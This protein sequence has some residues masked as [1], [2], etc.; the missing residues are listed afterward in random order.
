MAVVPLET[1]SNDPRLEVGD[2]GIDFL[3]SVL[4]DKCSVY[5]DIFKWRI[6]PMMSGDARMKK[7]C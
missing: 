1:H 3:V 2:D 6:L 5:I 7:G 4:G